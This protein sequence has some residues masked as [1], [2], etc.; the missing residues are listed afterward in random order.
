MANDIRTQEDI[1]RKMGI[2]ALNPMQEEALEV[3]GKNANTVLL[4]PTGTGKTLAFLLPLLE[5]LDAECSE[6]QGL[7][8]VPS[9]ELA[10]Q[11]EQVVREM[12]SGFKVNAVYGGR[13]ISKDKI[14]LK[15]TPAIL[16]GTPGRIADHF[17]GDRF[18]KSDIKTLVL[19]EFDKSLE[20]GF[21]GE[22]SEIINQLP[23]L[24]KRILT[25][26]TQGVEIPN[27]VRLDK[28]AF[29]DY[30]DTKRK[31]RLAIRT[32]ISPD[33]DKLQTLV[34]LLFHIGNQPGIIFCNYKDSIE[35]VSTFLDKNRIDHTCFSGGME[36]RDRE[37]SLIKFRNG[38][39]QVMIATDL[40]ARGID[41]PEMKYIIHYEL[42]RAVEEFTHRNGRTARVNAKGTAYVLQSKTEY[43]PEFIKDVEPVDISQ[44]GVRKPPYW[45]TLFISGG[46]KDKISKG[47]IAGLFFKQGGLKRDQLGVIELKQDCAFVAV[48]VSLANQ[49]I[50]KLNN[51]RLKNKKVRV[52]VL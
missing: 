42:P 38:T 23:N 49:M 40:A 52:S 1:L 6:V 14:E 5:T 39:C 35:R 10:I 25:S 36:Q 16:I 45:E 19:D 31:S 21:E 46:R 48:P 15:H 30:L 20:T 44:K 29:I 9:R 28:P 43:V 3:I 51:S 4:S 27:F 34:D 50:Q 33:K 8:L 17:G 12:G 37:R 13:P 7:I 26:A 18:T 41:I 47:D 11:I 24:E 2:E 32:V 22:M